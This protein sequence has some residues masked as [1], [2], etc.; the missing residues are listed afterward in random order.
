MRGLPEIVV[1]T[2]R[3]TTQL[4]ITLVS[5]NDHLFNSFDTRILTRHLGV[6]L[7]FNCIP[8]TNGQCKSC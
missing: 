4:N 2:T 3:L 7:T 5:N 8:P 1:L 6:L